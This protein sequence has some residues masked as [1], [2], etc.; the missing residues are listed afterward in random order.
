VPA[1]DAVLDLGAG[2]RTQPLTRADAD[3]HLALVERDRAALGRWLGWALTTATPAD[4]RDFLARAET[5]G[6]EDGL[7]WAG[8]WLDDRLVGGV[9]WFPVEKP[10]MASEVGYWLDSAVTGR[11]IMTRVLQ[12][13]LDRALDDVGLR[14]VGL[15]AAVDNTASRRVAE[16]LGF[17]FEGVRRCAWMVGDRVDDHAVYSLLRTDPRPWHG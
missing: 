3:D 4:A 14:R 6:A 7:P 8:I 10:V 9:L 2:L 5:R 1:L 12:P 17:M 11:G 16:R 13:L 15:Q